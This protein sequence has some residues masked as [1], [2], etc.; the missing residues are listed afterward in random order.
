MIEFS[1]NKRKKRCTLLEMNRLQ[2]VIVYIENWTGIDGLKSAA[3]RTSL[4]NVIE[5]FT[6]LTNILILRTAYRNNNKLVV[7]YLSI[8][9]CVISSLLPARTQAL[10]MLICWLVCPAHSQ[11]N[12]NTRK[13]LVS[14]QS[15][16]CGV[17]QYVYGIY[18]LVKYW[19]F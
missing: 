18:F 9:C 7:C 1:E 17:H 8:S 16:L 10:A 19:N 4:I 15:S 12:A 2:F 13:S 11:S 6:T 14:A 3:I 5:R